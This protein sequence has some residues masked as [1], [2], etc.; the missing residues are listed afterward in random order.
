MI[1]ISQLPPPCSHE[2]MSFQGSLRAQAGPQDLRYYL[3]VNIFRRS[4]IGIVSFCKPSTCLTL[5][6]PPVVFVWLWCLVLMSWRP[7]SGILDFMLKFET[8]PSLP[9]S[10]FC[11]GD[12]DPVRSRGRWPCDPPLIQPVVISCIRN[13]HGGFL[14]LKNH[15]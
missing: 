10:R 8:M 13:S 15:T 4:Y 11:P 14:L 12:L 9:K 3:S 5:K 6:S 7:L 1:D 2:M